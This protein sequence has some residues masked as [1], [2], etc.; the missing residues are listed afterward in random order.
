MSDQSHL[1]ERYFV[2]EET[3]NCPFCNR[4]NV[5]YRTHNIVTFNWD[6]KR[7]CQ[8]FFIKCS[9][10][11][12]ISMHLSYYDVYEI[13]NNLPYRD[14]F[15]KKFNG[16]IDNAIFHSVPTSFF[17]LD[18]RIPRVLRELLTEAESCLNGNHLTGGSACA[19]KLI[20]ELGKKEKATGT[21]YEEK[22]KSLKS[23][24]KEVDSTYFDTLLSIHEITSSKVH[25]NALD[26]W[27]ADY[28]RIILSAIKEILHEIY[29]IPAV[30]NDRRQEI[31][32]M[33]NSLTEKGEKQ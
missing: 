13:Y 28:L 3:Y 1:D 32:D 25:E 29:V 12:K 19:R 8:A 33:K 11:E 21:S 2:D 18:N 5:R 10:C 23:I 6:N 9:S 22:I 14:E 20:Y 31:I 24:R 30:R 15:N 27:K 26:G 17:A 4:K 7:E 16:L